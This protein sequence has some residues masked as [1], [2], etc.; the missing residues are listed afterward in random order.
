M[1]KRELKK[2]IAGLT[3]EQLEE[4][5]VLLYEKFPDVKT[6]YNFVF[7]PQEEKL[8]DEAK[9][10]I[11]D[12]YFPTRAK[13]AKLRRS[14]AQKFIRHFITLGVDPLVIADVMLFAIETAQKYSARRYVRY[15]SFYSSLLTAYKQAFDFSVKNGILSDMR[16]RLA[17]IPEVA[18]TQKWENHWDFATVW[19]R[20]D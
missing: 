7:N 9:A 10:K 13:R 15:T 18:R 14:V 8:A 1:A 12:E 3:K 19:S 6:Y 4:Q 5:F 11:A 20:I 2:Y 16:P 17:T